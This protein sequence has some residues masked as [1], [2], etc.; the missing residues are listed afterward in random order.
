MPV[1]GSGHIDGDETEEVSL[2]AF[3]EVEASGIT[4]YSTS[5]LKN[6]NRDIAD[7][8]QDESK[9]YNERASSIVAQVEGCGV[10]VARVGSAPSFQDPDST[11]VWYGSYASNM[12]SARFMCYIEGGQVEGMARACGGGR[13]RTPPVASRWLRVPHKLIFGHE[14]NSFWGS[15]GVAFLDPISHGGSPDTLIRIYKITLQQFCDVLAQEN[16]RDPNDSTVHSHL[17][18]DWNFINRLR[19]DLTA[20]HRTFDFF[21]GSWYGTLKYLR[22]EDGLPILTF[23][24]SIANMRRF[25]EGQLPVCAPSKSYSQVIIRGLLEHGLSEE[26]ATA[27]VK[28]HSPPYDPNCLRRVSMMNQM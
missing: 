19:S 16:R 21:P 20:R 3:R 9:D 2:S 10:E 7:I 4:E 23:T 17:T 1:S 26:E 13:N 8:V 5:E 22:D 11:Y 12:W 28:S 18:V 14:W 15:G 27:Y 24:C 25:S 6:E